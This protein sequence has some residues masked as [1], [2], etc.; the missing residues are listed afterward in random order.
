MLNFFNL[1]H[2]IF[3]E[4]RLYENVYNNSKISHLLLR[5]STRITRIF[6]TLGLPRCPAGHLRNFSFKLCYFL[7]LVMEA[8]LYQEPYIR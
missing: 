4:E 8:M 3:F 1:T 7:R 2:D 5:H 6:Y